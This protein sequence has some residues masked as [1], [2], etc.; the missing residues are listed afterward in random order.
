MGD[1]PT[2]PVK[3]FALATLSWFSPIR[4]PRLWSTLI[5]GIL[6][7]YEAG[8]PKSE[9]LRRITINYMKFGISAIEWVWYAAMGVSAGGRANFSPNCQL[10]VGDFSHVLG[11]QI[12]WSVVTRSALRA[13]GT[14]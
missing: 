3:G 9:H 6:C 11:R 1:T 5:G 7:P 13:W 12:A 14:M 8:T 10:A 2:S 4:R